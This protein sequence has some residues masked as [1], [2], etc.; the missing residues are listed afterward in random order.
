M[1]SAI[2]DGILNMIVPKADVSACPCGDQTS[3][4]WCLPS[5][6]WYCQTCHYSCDCT[7]KWCEGRNTGQRCV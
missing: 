6:W 7:Q 4:C 3:D 5:A 2:F 1:V